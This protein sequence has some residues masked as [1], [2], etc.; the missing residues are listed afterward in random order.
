MPYSLET[1][2]SGSMDSRV[3]LHC[4]GDS[5]SENDR[6]Y[7]C[8]SDRVKE[9]EVVATEPSLF[10]SVAEDGY[11]LEFDIREPHSCRGGDAPSC[12]GKSIYLAPG[13]LKSVSC[14]PLYSNMIAIASDQEDINLYDR[15]ML[16]AVN[17]ITQRAGFFTRPRLAA[18]TLDDADMDLGSDHETVYNPTYIEFSRTGGELLANY[19][20]DSI[21]LFD[22]MDHAIPASGIPSTRCL[23]PPSETH[24]YW[25]DL[26][27]EHTG[28]RLFMEDDF[29]E[30]TDPADDIHFRWLYTKFLVERTGADTLHRTELLLQ[31][32]KHTIN[33]APSSVF[34]LHDV[35]DAVQLCPYSP[36]VRYLYLI[37][38]QACNLKRTLDIEKERFLADFEDEEGTPEDLANVYHDLLT[39]DCL[40]KKVRSLT[41]DG[42]KE[43]VLP[44]SLDDEKKDEQAWASE[45]T[46]VHNRCSMSYMGRCNTRTDI[47]EASFFMDDYIIGGCDMGAV[48]IW[49]KKTGIMIQRFSISDDVIN[50]VPTHPTG[51][52]FAAGGIDDEFRIFGPVADKCE[53][54]DMNEYSTFVKNILEFAYW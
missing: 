17:G 46:V 42:S 45:N 16:Q 49:E 48:C 47:K 11:C 24:R 52:F 5:G 30:L 27:T 3:R 28:T 51:P 50:C 35:Y 10:W 39:W 15:R 6:V 9:V 41:V 31:R 53:T 38:V 54:E 20:G 22:M 34:A 33:V 14:N 2:V 7:R 21:F 32:A 8:H 26:S 23:Q 43:A 1:V 29:L 44:I 13:E 18:A 36:L 25:E 12:C 37:T 4:L 19:N 40:R